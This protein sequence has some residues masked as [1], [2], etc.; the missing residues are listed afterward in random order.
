MIRWFHRLQRPA[1]RAPIGISILG[2]AMLLPMIGSAKGAPDWVE[3]GGTSAEFQSARYLTGFAQAEGKQDA[4]ES[5]KQ[6]ASADLARQIS[7]QIESS[8]VDITK[9]TNGEIALSTQVPGD[10]VSDLLKAKL[11]P[12]PYYRENELAVQWIG[13]SRSGRAQERNC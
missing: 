12:D 4:L 10:I 7:V 9:E 1:R 6:L 5:A 3:R 13:E 11:I 8:V 2:L